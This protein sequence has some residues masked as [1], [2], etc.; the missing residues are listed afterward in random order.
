MANGL[1]HVDAHSRDGGKV[2]VA[3]HT[4]GTPGQGDGPK[5]WHGKSNPRFREKIAEA[6]NSPGDKGG[7]DGYQSH[8]EQ[9]TPPNPLG[10]YQLTTVALNQIKW[11]A[12]DKWTGKAQSH[13]VAS[14]KDFLKNPNA[15]EIAMD[16][17][18]LD[19]ERQT[20]VL[21]LNNHVG[22]TYGGVSGGSVTVTEAGIAAAGHRHGVPATKKYLQRRVNRRQAANARDRLT[23][24]QIEKGMRDFADL[25]YERGKR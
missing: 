6:E 12:G 9:F 14:D 8:K 1:V 21:G 5:P 19:N 10:R 2:Q 11:K 24:L 17:Y 20:Q 16:E 13:G 7:P 22:Q 25:P 15:Q 3:Q 18:L 4:R 23:D